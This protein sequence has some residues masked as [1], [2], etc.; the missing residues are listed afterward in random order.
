[1]NHPN[2]GG[3]PDAEENRVLGALEER[4]HALLK[5]GGPVL[6]VLAITTG[7]FKEFVFYLRDSDSIGP[8]HDRLRAEVSSHQIQCQAYRDPDWDVYAAFATA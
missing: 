3:L 6:H 5:A 7:S 8:V 1:L 2:P 4:I